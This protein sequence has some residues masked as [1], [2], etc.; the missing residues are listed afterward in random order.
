ML[1]WISIA[2]APV[3]EEGQQQLHPDDAHRTACGFRDLRDRRARIGDLPEITPQLTK[4]S[5][6]AHAKKLRMAARSPRSAPLRL[7][8]RLR[9][10]QA[11][12]AR[13]VLIHLHPPAAAIG[14]HQVHAIVHPRHDLLADIL[15]LGQFCAG[16]VHRIERPYRHLLDLG[17]ERGLAPAAGND[18]RLALRRRRRVLRAGGDGEGEEGEGEEGALHST[19]YQIT[20]KM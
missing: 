17:G 16:H 7:F 6:T 18:R 13:E 11:A 10:G 19:V 9:A 3:M 4:V 14:E 8:H 2:L 15:D 5:Q 12:L 1:A 20:R